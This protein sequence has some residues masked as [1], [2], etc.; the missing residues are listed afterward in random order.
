MI[1]LHKALLILLI[2]DHEPVVQIS[3]VECSHLADFLRFDELLTERGRCRSKIERLNWFA[4][5]GRGDGRI[6]QAM[7]IG[8]AA[9]HT[10]RH[11]KVNKA[12]SRLV[13][14]CDYFTSPL[15]LSSD[16]LSDSLVDL[17]YLEEIVQRG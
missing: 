15:L 4:G 3:L 8:A 10:L 12:L 2:L 17:F 11:F 7:G 14:K 1:P 13:L 5:S 6:L 9:S 16:L